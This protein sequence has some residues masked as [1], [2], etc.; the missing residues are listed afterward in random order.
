MN[1]SLRRHALRLAMVTVFAALLPGGL[2]SIR[3]DS[4]RR[5]ARDACAA[6]PSCPREQIVTE[7]V[8]EPPPGQANYLAWVVARGCGAEERYLCSQ[9]DATWRCH[10]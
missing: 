8:S 9:N 6:R 5:P 7:I 2:G 10:H 3:R 1:G 4:A